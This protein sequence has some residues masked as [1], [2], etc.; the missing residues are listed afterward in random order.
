MSIYDTYRRVCADLGKSP[1]SETE[2]NAIQ[3][4]DTETEFV[5]ALRELGGDVCK[6]VIEAVKG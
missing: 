5:N 4:E 1:I 2:F 6:K 3:V